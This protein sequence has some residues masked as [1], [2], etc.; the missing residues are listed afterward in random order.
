MMRFA[1]GMTIALLGLAYYA[2]YRQLSSRYL[3]MGLAGLALVGLLLT[4]GKWEYLTHRYGTE[5]ERIAVIEFDAARLPITTILK[6]DDIAFLKVYKYTDIEAQ[7]L[8][9][10]LHGNK[11]IMDLNRKSADH[12]WT[13]HNESGWQ[14]EMIHSTIGGTAHRRFYW[15]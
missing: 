12:L 15:Y 4:Y 13:S 9:Q 3:A 10:D 7:L 11:W 1:I 14:I 2:Y 8:L 5:F 6:A